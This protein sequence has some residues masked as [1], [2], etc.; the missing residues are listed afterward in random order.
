MANREIL[1]KV[2]FE[3][4]AE[5]L[6]RG[7]CPTCGKKIDATSFKDAGSKKE[8]EISGMCQECQDKTFG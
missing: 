5:A 2:G 6:E 3:K 4:E 1:K 8:F 7:D